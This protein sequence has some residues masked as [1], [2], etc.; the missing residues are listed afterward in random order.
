VQSVS[1][2]N[3]T[4]RMSVIEDFSAGYHARNGGG[5]SIVTDGNLPIVDVREVSSSAVSGGIVPDSTV[6]SSA[7]SDSTVSDTASG[8]TVP[9]TVSDS[10]VPNIASR[11]TVSSSVRHTIPP[12]PI[13]VGTALLLA[14]AAVALY[15]LATLV[16]SRTTAIRELEHTTT[17]TD[18]TSGGRVLGI[19]VV[20]IALFAVAE[21][22][23]AW[24]LYRGRNQARVLAMSLSSLVIVV[25][26]ISLAGGG[27]ALTL[28]ST[29]SGLSLDVLLV[30]ALSS[31]RAR[32]YTRDG[33]SERQQRARQRRQRTDDRP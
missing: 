16:M 5:D 25:Q 1:A 14:R 17:L 22:A 29:L 19:V 18:A 23:I 12:A 15:L 26:A 31:D 32:N 11:S 21:A 10:T 3:P 20:C 27:S 28:A 8:S 7:V 30:L 2:A 4:A 24:Q 6:S 13:V 33:G 9:G